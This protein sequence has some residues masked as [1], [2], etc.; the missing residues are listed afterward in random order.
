[1]SAL[2]FHP[3]VRVAPAVETRTRPR[4]VWT[5]L[6]LFLLLIRLPS[7]AQPAGGDQ[8]LYGYAGQRIL[9]SDVMYR[10]MWD[11]KPPAIAFTYALLWSVWPDEAVV[12]AADL[13]AAAAVAGLLVVLG[14]RR[15]SA[16]IGYGAAVLFLLLGDPYLQR[17]SGVYV[18]GQCEPFM[19]LA[20]TVGLVLLAAPHR[21]RAHLVAAG[22]ALA[23][24]FWLKYNA[25]AYAIPLAAAAWAW[26]GHPMR[27]RPSR[28]APL[29]W[30]AL[31]FT[32]VA[33]LVLGYFALHGALYDLRLAT[34][35]YN[36]RYSNETYEG[37]STVL[38]Y[39]GT[40]P[41][42]RAR[43][44]MLWFVGGLGALLLVPR[45][46]HDRSALLVLAWLVAA[47]LSI[48]INGSRSL[49]NYF[50]QAHPALALAASA[51]LAT[52]AAR[53]VVLR[54]LVGLLLALALWRVGAD[55]PVAGLRLASMPGLVENVR[56]D[57]AHLG[58][59]MDRDAYL[60]RFRGQK[61]DAQENERL[62]QYIRTQTAPDDPIFVFGFSGGSVGW[63]SER[64]SASRFYWSRP[65][66]IG[67]AA[68]H[69]G[70][71]TGGLLGDLRNR[72]PAVVALQKDEWQS[73]AFFL[74]DPDLRS[75]LESG[76]ALERET[77]MFSIWRRND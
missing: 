15:Y 4:W 13:A 10:D 17:L 6:I 45:I 64:V 54:A 66:I 65:V 30:V 60:G 51:G 9:A 43:V 38:R 47:V 34:L 55:A 7:L 21:R 24:A 75:W 2:P 37:S 52:L 22:V 39:V 14:R 74:G 63:K 3:N 50:V 26:N 40:M 33:A 72:A 68:D 32:A 12:A 70:Y 18:R 1:V 5:A 59:R 67:F 25:A 20:V 62:V 76:Y 49:P 19:A 31:G 53:G 16:G 57:V 44:D 23:A 11:Q 69:A 36:L 48:A 28:L 73:R 42:E 29:A 56:Y 27:D 46:R 77:A 61:H 41:F 71:G 58:G 8:G 35:D